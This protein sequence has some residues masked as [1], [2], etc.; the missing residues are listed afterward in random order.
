MKV[1]LSL[2][3]L[4]TLCL[5]I[6]SA[7][8]RKEDKVETYKY[9]VGQSLSVDGSTDPSILQTSP[10]YSVAVEGQEQ[11]VLVT[12]ADREDVD[13]IHPPVDTL[14]YNAIDHPNICAFGCKGKVKVEVALKA[15][16]I[17][18]VEILPV[19]KKP[20]YSVKKG[21][22]CVE[23][24]PYDRYIVKINGDEGN[25]LLLFANP[26][27]SEMGVDLN[28]PDVLRFEAG[29]VYSDVKIRPRNGQTVFIE[30]GAIVVGHIEAH[31]VSCHVNGPGV[32]NC[33][34]EKGK[35]VYLYKCHDSSLKNL[36][37]LNKA[38]WATA[39]C[40]CSNIQIE[41]WHAISTY[42]PYDKAG[43][44][45]DTCKLVRFDTERIIMAIAEAVSNGH[46]I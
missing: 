20:R 15:S 28:S 23:M 12:G 4:L 27:Q 45:N 44:N 11:F 22:L 10:I 14:S 30:G 13:R 38:S 41:N 2:L 36:I 32:L 5:S 6:F 43:V 18:K 7:Y 39:I 8:G 9:P 24:K 33:Y 3:C 31:N 46:S 29:K 1:K 42:S 16:R 17:E 40:M 25:L 19:S 21:K 37:V 35:G 26:F 34:P